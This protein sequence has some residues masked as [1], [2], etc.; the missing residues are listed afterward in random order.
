MFIGA[1]NKVKFP[2]LRRYDARDGPRESE[3]SCSP[4]LKRGCRSYRRDTTRH[5]ATGQSATAV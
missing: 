3:I 4:C 1:N 2:P 5:D